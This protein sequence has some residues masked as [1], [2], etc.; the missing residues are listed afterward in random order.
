MHEGKGHCMK[1]LII[2]ADTKRPFSYEKILL[3]V[4]GKDSGSLTCTTDD[5]GLIEL[6]DKYAGQQVGFFLQTNLEGKWLTVIHG[7]ILE[8]AAEIVPTAFVTKQTND[9]IL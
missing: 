6:D 7:A 9:T 5:A 8:L 4:K 3:Q 2:N 1:L